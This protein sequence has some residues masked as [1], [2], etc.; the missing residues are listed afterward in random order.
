MAVQHTSG[1]VSGLSP[2]GLSVSPSCSARS[3]NHLLATPR[4]HLPSCHLHLNPSKR[5]VNPALTSTQPQQSVY[6]S[7][8]LI[9]TPRQHSRLSIKSSC[10]TGL[11]LQTRSPQRPHTNHHHARGRSLRPLHP[12]RPGRRCFSWSRVT[13][14]RQCAHP[15]AA[16]GKLHLRFLE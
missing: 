8:R 2:L 6:I 1:Y 7:K 11:R 16:S 10:P 13:A 5:T 12:Q 9:V 15:G 4:L 14:G 3:P